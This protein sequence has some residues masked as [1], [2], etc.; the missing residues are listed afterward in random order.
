[1]PGVLIDQV[2]GLADPLKNYQFLM[3]ISPI[4]GANIVGNDVFSLRCTGTSMPGSS[5]GQVPVD[6]AGFQLRYPGRRM[7][8]PTWSTQLV[9]GQDL[10]ITQQLASWMKLIYDQRT[11]VASFK[12]DISSIAVV[13]IYDDP[14]NVVGVR[15]LSGIW[16]LV[17]PGFGL[18]FAGAGAATP[19]NIVWSFDIWDDPD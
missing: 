1:M 14:N 3:N 9:E 12:A 13:E 5:L 7:F 6:L 8:E 17:D 4:R 2:Q 10:A 11:G 19:L 15:T 18:S 16:P